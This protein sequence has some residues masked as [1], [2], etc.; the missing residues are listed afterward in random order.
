MLPPI[1]QLPSLASES[2][3]KRWC[4]AAAVCTSCKMQPESTVI[5]LSARLT[6]RMRLSLLKLSS[7]PLWAMLPPTVPVLPPCGVMGMRFAAQKRTIFCTL[8]TL[9]G[10]TTRQLA[11]V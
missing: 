9:I 11:L 10:C 3:K 1:W 2:G 4:A 6:R 5:V 8:S 7:T